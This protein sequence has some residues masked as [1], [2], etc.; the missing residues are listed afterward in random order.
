MGIDRNDEQANGKAH[1][2]A[3]F[4][5]EDVKITSLCFSEKREGGRRAC[6]VQQPSFLRRDLLQ[7]FREAPLFSVFV[8]TSVSGSGSIYVPAPSPPPL[9]L[10]QMLY[11]YPPP[12]YLCFSAFRYFIFSPLSTWWKPSPSPEKWQCNGMHPAI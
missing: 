7:R 1:L 11:S 3:P 6:V 5:Q 2:S 10:S 8:L 4:V 12:Q 9:F